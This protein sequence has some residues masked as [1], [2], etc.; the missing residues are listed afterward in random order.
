[1]G[2][3]ASFRRA[4]EALSA[5]DE[6]PGYGNKDDRDDGGTENDFVCVHVFLQAMALGRAQSC[7][8]PIATTLRDQGTTRPACAR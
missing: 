5:L 8:R 1:M 4:P 3:A 2:G 6:G 7:Q